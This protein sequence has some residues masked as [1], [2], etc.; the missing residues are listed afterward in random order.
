M[1]FPNGPNGN[2]NIEYLGNYLYNG[3]WVEPSLFTQIVKRAMKLFNNE[4]NL[5]FLHDPITIVGDLHGQLY[6]M[7]HMFNLPNLKNK[8]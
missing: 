6:D 7:F 2:V 8:F 5:V 3:G 4:P 1:V